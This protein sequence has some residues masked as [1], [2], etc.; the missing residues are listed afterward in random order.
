[1]AGSI[2]EARHTGA[3]P[4]RVLLLPPELRPC[5]TNGSPYRWIIVSTHVVDF[6]GLQAT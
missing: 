6:G 4:N 2:R 3:S 5:P 1:M